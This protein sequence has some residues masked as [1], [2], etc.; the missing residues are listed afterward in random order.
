MVHKH[1][2]SVLE[3][4]SL[5][6]INEK[7]TNALEIC[8]DIQ[9]GCVLSLLLFNLY[10]EHIFEEA[11]EKSRRV[12]KKKKVKEVEK[13]KRSSERHINKGISIDNLLHNQ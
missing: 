6:K 10:S 3:S 12:K 11:L 4:S 2:E 7:T 8:R 9:Q 13:S 5:I 1:C